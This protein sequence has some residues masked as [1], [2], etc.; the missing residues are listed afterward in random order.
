MTV[1]SEVNRAG[2]YLGNG[3]TTVFGFGFR[4]LSASHL[5]VIITD[6]DGVE[7]DIPYP[8]GYSVTGVG[9]SAGGSITISPAPITGSSITIL[10]NVPMVQETDL[11]NQGAYYAETVERQFDL[12]VMQNQQQSEELRRAV[13]VPAS[14]EG[15]VGEL[16]ADLALNITRLGRSAD[17]IDAVAGSIGAVVTAAGSVSEID[18]VAENI[19]AVV[20]ASGSVLDLRP[21][22]YVAGGSSGQ[23]ILPGAPTSASNVLVWVSGVRQVPDADYT[24]NGTSLQ[25]IAVP[26]EGT[27]I[28]VL[29]VSAVSMDDVEALV[30]RAEAAA[31]QGAASAGVLPFPSRAALAA[32]VTASGPAANGRVVSVGGIL[33][34]VDPTATGTAS[35]LHDLGVSG[36]RL[37]GRVIEGRWFGVADGV[38]DAA[39]AITAANTYA[40][41]QKGGANS[42]VLKLEGAVDLRDPVTLGGATALFHIDWSGLTVNVATGG[43]LA[44]TPTLFAVTCEAANSQ[45]TCGRVNAN[46]VCNGIRF[47]DC[48]NSYAQAPNVRRYVT[49]G[50]EVTGNSAGF[51]VD[52]PHSV[53]WVTSDPQYFVEA[54]YVGTGLRADSADF[55]ISKGQVGWCKYALWITANAG[56]FEAHGFH[57]FNGDVSGTV[58]R[59]HPFCVVNE[60]AGPAFLYDCYIDNGY[61]DDRSGTLRIQGGW[62][63]TLLNRVNLAQPYVRIRMP[64]VVTNYTGTI[65]DFDSSVGFYTGAWVNNGSNLLTTIAM[66]LVGQRGPSRISEVAR[67]RSRIIPESSDTVD[68]YTTKQGASGTIIRQRYQPGASDA[69]RVDVEFYLGKMRLNNGTGNGELVLSNNS[70]TGIKGEGERLD[71][72][73]NGNLRAIF[74]D[75]G[76]FRPAT[77]NTQVLGTSAFRW[78]VVHA[79]T[80]AINTSDERLKADIRELSDAEARVA[81][82]I[83]GMVRAYR[84]RDAVAEKGDGARWHF[85]VIAQEVAEAFAAEGLNPF[86]YGVVCFDQWDEQDEQMDPTTGEVI[87]PYQAAGD[88][89]GVRY[90]ELMMFVLAVM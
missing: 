51:K 13:K 90:D 29:V 69:D 24:V 89:W 32:Y 3:S 68:D 27:E 50:I 72:Y 43:A 36:V 70:R 54:A 45:I 81:Q 82:A 76:G 37:Y 30:E 67:R 58:P 25:L 75:N 47:R 71:V 63:L 5:R 77:D 85:G 35:A 66:D 16:A 44:A 11:E 20:D 2:P 26:S 60:A 12:I 53:E 34:S 28:D 38:A 80:G 88:R 64:A 10:R 62:H 59:Q 8:S 57:P 86:D 23:F 40:K 48:G 17:S 39:T 52:T 41:N 33:A 21:Q 9:A 78:S 14:E 84:F 55:V 19:Q 73:T 15:N 79:A 22:S 46:K 49:V 65:S 42:V 87:V 74:P 4:I 7:T 56:G 31:N 18:R 6:E 61:I 1:S 83:K